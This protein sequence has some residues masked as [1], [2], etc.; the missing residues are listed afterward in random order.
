M[1][2]QKAL[3]QK[4]EWWEGRRALKN[5]M[6]KYSYDIMY[7][8]EDLLYSRY[9]ST[10][11][12]V[13][14]GM[15]NGYYVGAEAI[16]TY[17]HSVSSWI[18][19]Q[20]KLMRDYFPETLGKKTD[21]EVFGIGY[22]EFKPMAM[23]VIA[24]AEDRKTAKGMWYSRGSYAKVMKSGPVSYWTWGVFCV[25]FVREDDEWK[26]WHI[27]YLE[28][29]HH[30]AG[31]D[32]TKP[33]VPFPDEPGFEKAEDFPVAEPN[34]PQKLRELYTPN[35]PFCRLPDFPMAYRTFSETFSYGYEGEKI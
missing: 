2:E 28:D 27:L 29:I 24:I 15:N 19:F 33:D 9:W 25:D 12:D 23:P 17:Y 34:I 26:I 7:N 18:A 11:E 31:Q 4:L 3:E 10:R 6:G 35:R 8:R 13:S 32:W 1:L 14:L 20:G 5:I 21:E 16:Q 22:W 30:M